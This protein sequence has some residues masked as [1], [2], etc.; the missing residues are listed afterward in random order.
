MLSFG[1]VAQLS[2]ASASGS[3]PESLA[4]NASAL[5]PFAVSYVAGA[6]E[7]SNGTKYCSGV[8]VAPKFVKLLA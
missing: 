8:L 3:F 5:Y 2:I 4:V 1:S 6:R 7:T